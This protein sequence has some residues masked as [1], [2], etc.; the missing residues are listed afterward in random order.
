MGDVW[1]NA[2]CILLTKLLLLK[3]SEMSRALIKRVQ[4]WAF[5]LWENIVNHARFRLSFSYRVVERHI[6][7][8]LQLLHVGILD[9][10]EPKNI[11]EISDLRIKNNRESFRDVKYSIYL[12]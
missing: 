4:T 10:E 6:S 8:V 11:E 12:N 2:S 3:R 5:N 7:T 9:T 1:S